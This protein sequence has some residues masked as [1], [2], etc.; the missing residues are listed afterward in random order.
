M[1]RVDKLGNCL[2]LSCWLAGIIVGVA[3]SDSAMQALYWAGP[4][5]WEAG[6]K[7]SALFNP[8]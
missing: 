5:G 4:V 1:R 2:Y 6:K 3:Y 8:Y 7:I